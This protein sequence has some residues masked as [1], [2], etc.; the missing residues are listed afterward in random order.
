MSKVKERGVRREPLRQLQVFRADLADNTTEKS[1]M[2]SHPSRFAEDPDE[3]RQGSFR[4]PTSQTPCPVKAINTG[5]QIDRVYKTI[6]V[7]LDR[8]YR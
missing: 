4:K 7:S 5:F 1:K 2:K 3:G 8:R 6:S